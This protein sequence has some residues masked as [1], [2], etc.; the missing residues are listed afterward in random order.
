MAGKISV[1]A[2]LAPSF[3]RRKMLLGTS[4]L[5]CTTLRVSGGVLTFRSSW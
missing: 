5:R 4:N 3:T 1:N 2:A